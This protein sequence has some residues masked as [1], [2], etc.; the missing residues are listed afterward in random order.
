[1]S[2]Q[3]ITLKGKT[4]EEAQIIQTIN[5]MILGNLNNTSA[6]TLTANSATTTVTNS[7]VAANSFLSFMPTTANAATELAAGTMYVSSQNKGEFTITHANNVQTDRTFSY[8]H[9]G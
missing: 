8:M 9:V 6:I 4:K 5:Q 3:Q 2:L 7:R 1:M